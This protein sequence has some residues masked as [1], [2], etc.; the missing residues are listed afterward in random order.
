MASTIIVYEGSASDRAQF[1]RFWKALGGEAQGLVLEDGTPFR[2]P[3]PT[4]ATR[5]APSR[6]QRIILVALLVAV[7][8]NVALVA[9]FAW[10]SR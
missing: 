4:V 3:E 1:W 2:P 6:Q 5:D 10:M 9:L 7:T 8:I